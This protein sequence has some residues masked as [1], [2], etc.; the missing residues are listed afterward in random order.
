MAER[1]ALSMLVQARV[2]EADTLAQLDAIV[3]RHVT[4]SGCDVAPEEGPLARITPK[5]DRSGLALRVG[6][7]LEVATAEEIS[8]ELV[9]TLPHDSHITHV[10][11]YHDT[12]SDEF[13]LNV[14]QDAYDQP[15]PLREEDVRDALEQIGVR[16]GEERSIGKSLFFRKAEL[17]A[18]VFEKLCH[19]LTKGTVKEF[20]I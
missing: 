14:P 20:G 9:L 6:T 10:E 12:T 17:M 4:F 1:D 11:L 3:R 5:E 18:T 2:R 19:D 16:V 13:F 7:P 8:I 15:G